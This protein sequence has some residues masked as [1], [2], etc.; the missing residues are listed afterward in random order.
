M[1]N[2]GKWLISFQFIS[3]VIAIASLVA[4]LL[5]F[6]EMRDISLETKNINQE[7]IDV[8]REIDILALERKQAEIEISSNIVPVLNSSNRWEAKIHLNNQG[9]ATPEKFLLELWISGQNEE[10]DISTRHADIREKSISMFYHDY[11]VENF[12]NNGY[13]ILTIRTT[14]DDDKNK[15]VTEIY[16]NQSESDWIWTDSAQEF[17]Y[18]DVYGTNVDMHWRHY[19]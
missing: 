4:M 7:M 14:L 5:I 13:I 19:D 12:V 8:S 10:I 18:I 16:G 15:L 1:M 3:M 6:F 17:V 2:R 9:P 11:W